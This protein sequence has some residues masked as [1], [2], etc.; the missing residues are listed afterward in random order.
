MARS[1]TRKKS[2]KAATPDSTKPLP[3]PVTA[4]AK[5]RAKSLKT[6][7]PPALA[8]KITEI[9]AEKATRQIKNWTTQ[10]ITHLHKVDRTP[11]CVPTSDG[12]RIGLYKLNCQDNRYRLYDASQIFVH[13]FDSKASAV[14]YAIFSIKNNVIKAAE[15]L[16]L[17][18]DINKNYMDVVMLSRRITGLQRQNDWTGAEIREY[19]LEI[20]QRRL[21]A[22]RD[23]IS[24]IHRSAKYN[25]IWD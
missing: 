5:P 1:R 11:V 13:E 25:K 8:P 9:D 6:K 14:L 17:D 19:R 23:K 18:Q 21:E 24:K 3:A 22:L 12:Y 16:D 4:R 2:P 15:I 7:T 10:E 20:A